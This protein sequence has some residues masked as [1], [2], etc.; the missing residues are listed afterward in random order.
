MNDCL[1]CDPNDLT[2]EALLE[3]SEN[4]KLILDLFPVSF[5][6]IIVIPTRHVESIDELNSK[7]MKELRNSI[8]E[9][10]TIAKKKNFVNKQYSN[11][12]K[13]KNRS[14]K[15]IESLK[16]RKSNIQGF[17]IGINE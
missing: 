15:M 11:I 4:F 16:N 13:H 9:A 3:N 5:G 2:N 1:F 8:S 6:H 12:S 17:N 14:K 7:E 10:K